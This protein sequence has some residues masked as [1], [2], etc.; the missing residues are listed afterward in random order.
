M[1]APIP[2]FAG[3]IPYAGKDQR[4]P[5]NPGRGR[6][7]QSVITRNG[8]LIILA[9]SSEES[10]DEVLRDTASHLYQATQPLYGAIEPHYPGEKRGFGYA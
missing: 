8:S 4:E 3:I 10:T 1:P 9:G 2:P 7:D 6:T 5:E